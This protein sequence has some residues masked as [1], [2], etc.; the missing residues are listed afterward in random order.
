[1]ASRIR[2]WQRLI[3]LTNRETALEKELSWMTLA[4]MKT[5][6][7]PTLLADMR[8]L[9]MALRLALIRKQRRAI[10]R[11]LGIPSQ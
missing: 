6:R 1:M 11:L 2:I 3:R 4:Q 5:S 10:S 8:F 7:L 9:R